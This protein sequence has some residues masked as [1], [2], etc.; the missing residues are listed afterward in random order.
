[1][2]AARISANEIFSGIPN[3]RANQFRISEMKPRIQPALNQRSQ[4]PG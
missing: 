3:Y 4:L 2:P 1:M